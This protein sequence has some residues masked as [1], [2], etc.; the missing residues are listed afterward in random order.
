MNVAVL[1]LWHLGTVA[2]ACLAD[3][4]ENVIAIDDV[5]V[6]SSLLL[7]QLPVNEPGLGALTQ[8]CVEK[9]TLTFSS[10]VSK[11]ASADIILVAYDTPVDDE[12]RADVAFVRTRLLA[13]LQHAKDGAV[14]L[15]SSQLPVGS[16]DEIA[17]ACEKQNAKA[18][19]HFAYSPENLRLGRAIQC[20]TKP[21]RI[22]VGTTS[23]TARS[24]IEQL[25]G[26]YC[27]KFIWMSPVSAEMT[28][29]ALNAYLGLSIT[30]I[31]E[32]ASI[33][34]LVGAD[35]RDVERGLKSEERIGDKAPLSPGAAFAGGTL[36]RDVAYLVQIADSRGAKKPLLSAIKM[37]NEEH[38]KWALKRLQLELGQLQ[39][40]VVT[41]LGLTYKPGTDTLRRSSS[42]ELCRSLK[43]AGAIVRAHDPAVKELPSDVS[44]C[45]ELKSSLSEA[46]K[47]ARAV[48]VATAWPEYKEITA[49]DLSRI[50]HNPLV[51]D[52]GAFLR[53]TLAGA[54]NIKYVSV[55]KS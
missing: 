6:V 29:H 21:D 2:A 11:L 53:P 12:D 32:I 37:S 55:G 4:G 9:K 28:K 52:A 5:E 3:A 46:L 31:N 8:K 18:K 41:V 19:L 7:G 48:V 35:A 45:V 43:E 34:E 14:V 23:D 20:F 49:A 24:R 30:F 26:R 51:L 22:V 36:A 38:K 54:K 17:G 25:Y 15:I 39:G 27:D 16:T 47:D 44:N 13:A 40:Q 33:C 42:V 50:M 10:D 1:G